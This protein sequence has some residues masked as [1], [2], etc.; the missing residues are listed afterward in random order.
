MIRPDGL[1]KILDFGLAKLREVHDDGATLLR[2]GTGVTMGTLSYMSPEQ[3]SGG[4][5]TPA[6]DVFS[7]GVV[8]YEMLSGSRPFEGAMPTDIAAAIL[9]K[10]PNP[11]EA[12]PKLSAI[13]MRALK[14]KPEERYATAGEMLEDLRHITGAPQVAGAAPSGPRS[15]T[16]LIAVATVVLV[17]FAALAIWMTMRTKEKERAQE[18]IATAER[19]LAERNFPGAFETASAALAILPAEQRL[20]DVIAK[21]S[22]RASFESDPPGANVWLER[23]KPSGERF[24][25]GVTPLTIDQLPHA[26]YVVTFEKEGLATARTT[27]PQYPLT[28]LGEA[29]PVRPATVTIRLIEASRVPEEMV[30]VPGGEY[31]LA[32][33]H[34]T[35]DAA[36]QLRDFLI[37]RFEV[38]N[39]DYE[40][41]V[42]GGGYRRPELWKTLPFEEVEKHFRDTTGLPGPREWA[43]G[44]PRPGLEMHP[45]TG[46]SW[47]EANAYAA[48]K[49]KQL[50]TI[51]QWEKAARYPQT[52][53]PANSFPW[54]L[55]SEG[56]D[57]TERMNFK[58][59]GTLPVDSM[60]VGLGPYGAHHMAGNVAE[61]TRNPLPPGYAVRGGGWNDALYSFGKT[62]ALPAM[63]ASSE[64]GFRC[65]KPLEGDG[66]EQGEFALRS[67]PVIPAYE[68]VDDAAFEE[69]RARY[70]Y[71]ST[72]LKAAVV[73]RIDQGDW[74]R[75]R[76]EY[77]VDG[78]TVPAYLYLPKNFRRPLQVVHFSP[79]GDVYSGWRTL[80]QSVEISLG[81]VL[82]GGRAIYAI[83]IPGFIGRPRPEGFVRPDSRSAEAVDYTVRQV[84]E[85]Q[86]GLDYLETRPDIDRS[87]IAFYAQSA[88]TGTG[89]VLGAVESRY[90]SI[91]FVG[92]GIWPDEVT[93]TPAANRINFVP[94]IGGRK[95]MLQGR[96][97]DAAPLES[98]AMPLFNLLSEPKRLEVFEGGHVPTQQILIPT[99]TRFLDKTLGKVE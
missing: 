59:R 12:P 25:A 69:I 64:L 66:S 78:Q 38:S 7:F 23:F 63:Y 40:I 31:R 62:A 39:R 95:L 14:K 96:Y 18:S 84:R 75:E 60:P 73:E 27:L 88:G 80:P 77:E 82:R 17:A 20:R 10:A 28:H 58:G 30:A 99:V 93:N 11:L 29:A 35:S 49:G 8:L 13:V 89:V 6:A 91:L 4:S 92:C 32:G 41:F 42:R 5:I 70:A 48:W 2:T 24:L 94:R 21:S 57:A 44:A 71:E 76:I 65:V 56:V 16:R 98:T 36:V 15:R 74:I 47:H 46:V 33:W 52:F 61:W 9:T 53:G 87:R 1:T 3:L 54:G 34:R 45:V 68:P 67:S 81:A 72:P 51:Y 43:G 97:D 85:L 83:V 19:L 22:E 79:A 90:R 26:D 37:D 86:R 55:V 50:P